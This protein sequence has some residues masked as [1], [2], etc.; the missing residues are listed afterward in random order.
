MGESQLLSSASRWLSDCFIG[1]RQLLS[2]ASRSVSGCF[3]FATT[4]CCFTV[5]CSGPCCYGTLCAEGWPWVSRVACSRLS[6]FTAA[7]HAPHAR[8]ATLRTVASIILSRHGPAWTME[9]Y[10][11]TLSFPLRASAFSVAA[12]GPTLVSPACRPHVRPC[13]CVLLACSRSGWRGCCFHSPVPFPL[14]VTP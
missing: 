4:A 11:L 12:R 14:T 2:S 10:C 1:E 13:V 7:A 9:V 3:T 5:A 8:R 6:F